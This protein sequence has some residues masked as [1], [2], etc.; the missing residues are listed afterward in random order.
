MRRLP[1]WLTTGAQPARL[2]H[3][4]QSARELVMRYGWNATAYQ[5]LNPGIQHWFHPNGEAVVGYLR[6]HR[7]L[8]VAGAPVCAAGDL[9]AIAQAFEQYA[10]RQSCRVCYVCAAQ[11]LRDLFQHSPRHCEIAVGREPVWNPLHWPDIVQRRRSL[12]AQLNRAANKSVHIEKTDPASAAGDPEFHRVLADWIATRG[13]PPLH[14]MVEPEVLRGVL[15]DRLVFAA[16]RDNRLVAYLIASPVPARNGYLIEELARSREAPNGASELLIDT[17]M[18]HFAAANCDYVTMGL[19]ALS[20]DELKRNP[21]WLRA[22][23]FFAR[24]HANRF[25][26]FRGLEQ[27]RAKM[28]PGRWENI[29]FIANEKRFSLAALYAVGAAFSGISPIRAVALG[30]I[31]GALQEIRNLRPRAR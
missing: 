1:A 3:K 16:R 7:Y 2:P 24:A 21:A 28:E 8:L 20:G 27:F 23:M 31:K 6:K 29:S 11:R 22:L 10:A 12:R 9:S 25:Y 14:F 5:I 30:A 15:D 13:L 26:N 17:A 18:R 19:V 4:V